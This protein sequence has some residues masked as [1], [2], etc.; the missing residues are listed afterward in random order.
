MFNIKIQ[1]IKKVYGVSLYS[2]DQVFIKSG[3]CRSLGNTITYKGALALAA[4]I[5]IGLRA[6]GREPV[7]VI[8]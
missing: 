1:Y 7:E 6:K 2:I 4:E 5:T 3:E 8:A